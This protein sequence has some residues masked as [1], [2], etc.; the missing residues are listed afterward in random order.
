MSVNLGALVI[1][2]LC[3]GAAAPQPPRPNSIRYTTLPQRPANAIGGAKFMESLD[4]MKLADREAAILREI[5][6]GNFP[7]FLRSLKSVEIRGTIRD[8][9]GE[10][11]VTARLHVMPDYLA[12]GSDADFVR[13]PMTPQTSQR[14]AD[15]FGCV[16][17]TRKIVDA[18]D[19]QA[20]LHLAPHPLTHAR[21]AVAT[22][23]EHHK[24][25]EKQR[26]D[27]LLGMLLT[28][29]KKD[30][31]LSPRIFER[32]DRLAIYGWR[33]LDGKPIQP[34][35]IVHSNRYVDYSHGAR[36]IG[37]AIELG[38]KSV[39]ITDLLRDPVHCGLVSD[40]GPIVPPRYP[41]D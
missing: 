6:R 19:Q 11:E 38:G 28:G 21:E 1:V 5:A 22:F 25:I 37:N 4:G 7:E 40:E 3:A 16:L 41:L 31:V 8:G 35:T 2:A 23:L 34:L 27:K 9:N 18:I 33:Q 14:I 13:M 30:I 10:R 39:R 26:A 20:Q 24:N 32:P 17:P 29:I 15:C 12:V 36:L